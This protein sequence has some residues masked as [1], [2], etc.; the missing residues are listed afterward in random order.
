MTGKESVN[1]I[2]YHQGCLY[3]SSKPECKSCNGFGKNLNEKNDKYDCYMTKDI[4]EEYLDVKN[5]PWRD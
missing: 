4:I 3:N 2:I 5:N 1:R